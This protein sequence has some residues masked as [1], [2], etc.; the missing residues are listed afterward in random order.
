DWLP[1]LLIIFIYENLHDFAILFSQYDIAPFLYQADLWMFGV[2]PTLW[3]Q[4]ITTPWL[5]DVMAILYAPYIAYAMILMAF[6]TLLG[7]RPAFKQISLA[8]I[9]TFI[10][11]FICYIVFPALPPRFYIHDL[12]TNPPSLNGSALHDLLQGTWDGLSVNRGAAFPSLHTALSSVALFYAFRY[13]NERKLF[14][15]TFWIYLPLIVGLWSSTIYLRHHWVL[16]IFAG[17]TVAAIACF[18]SQ[19]ISYWTQRYQ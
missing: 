14:K 13:R 7:Y 6:Y 10:L 2:S 17:W 19:K 8:V 15:I 9:F 18:T 16:D 11:G 1:F 12:F 3:A 5:T 4:K